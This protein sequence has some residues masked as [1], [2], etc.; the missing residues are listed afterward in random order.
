M[1]AA[2]TPRTM[3]EPAWIIKW[4]AREALK[5]G[6]PEEAHGLLDQ[7]LA[8]GNRRAFALRTDVIRGYLERAERSLKRDDVESAWGD[9]LRV[10]KIASSD[11]N[12]IRLRDTL[13]KL[14]LV[15][16][17]TEL[18]SGN[19][20]QALQAISL[21]KDRPAQ[22]PEI[23][24]L[25][26]ACQDWILTVEIAERG[27]FVLARSALERI[28]RRLGTHTA[29]LDRFEQDLIRR[30]DR[31]RFAWNEL[32]EAAESKN[33]R[34][35][36]R[37]ADEVLAMAPRHRQAQQI[38]NQAWQ[39]VQLETAVYNKG[40]TKPAEASPVAALGGG[41]QQKAALSLDSTREAAD[42]VL[43]KRFFLWIDGVGAWLVCLGSRISIGQ[44]TPDAGPV[45]V[46][47][48]AD[49]SRIHA[50][51]TRDEESYCLETN[52][53]VFVNDKPVSK[54]VLR[55]GDRLTI[56]SCPMLFEQPVPGCLSARLTLGGA[57]RLPMAVDGVLLMADMLVMGPGEKVHIAVPEMT[58]P[59]YLFR[60]KD[61]LG[62]RWAGEFIV[63]GQ[64]EKDRAL[65]P[66]QGTIS[67]EQFTF[68]IESVIGK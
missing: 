29:G 55:T 50:S 25:E 7:L 57:R 39:V 34:N 19:S 28:R 31:F 6:Q 46:P 44:A 17:R 23:T 27:D 48:F 43:P 14:D 4:R 21:L 16:I 60:Q 30:E 62:V 54:V 5:N 45:D 32:Q 61:R 51:M 2:I 63:E 8:A 36:L 35:M 37:L 66:A 68:A 67:S 65:L 20:L 1:I 9:L 40:S 41:L 58:Q 18:E 49:V 22:S 59:L 52:R 24:P 13:T 64:K 12:V 53:D 56:A 42:P 47:L 26:E 38:R 15:R 33:W 3:S 11:S 10:E